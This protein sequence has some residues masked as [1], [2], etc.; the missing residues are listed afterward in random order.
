MC[1][2]KNRSFALSFRFCRQKFLTRRE[3]NVCEKK[4]S[5]TLVETFQTNISKTPRKPLCARKTLKSTPRGVVG[6]KFLNVVAPQKLPEVLS[7]Q[8]APQGGHGADGADGGRTT[9][10]SKVSSTAQLK[11][12]C[13]FPHKKNEKKIVTGNSSGRTLSHF[14]PAIVSASS[15]PLKGIPYIPYII[16]P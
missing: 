4:S 1:A 14:F 2:K 11:A 16:S 7:A 15:H 3:K 5:G 12:N 8:G 13:Q 10:Q 6:A 9:R